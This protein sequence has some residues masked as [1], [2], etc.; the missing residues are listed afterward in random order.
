MQDSPVYVEWLETD[1]D[2]EGWAPA[3]KKRLLL[4]LYI[5][6]VVFSVI[7]WLALY[8]VGQ[9]FPALETVS[10]SIQIAAFLALEVVFCRIDLPAP[11]R[12]FLSI[13]LA[14]VRVHDDTLARIL[15]HRLP[16]IPET[17]KDNES[18]MSMILATLFVNTAGKT[19]TRWSMW[20]PP[21][22][23]FGTTLDPAQGIGVYLLLGAVEM[24][25]G[26]MIFK[27]QRGA[28]L[29]GTAYFGA[30]LVST[31][32]SWDLWDAWMREYTIQRRSFQGIP[33]R[34]GEIEQMQSLVPEA[35]LAFLTAGLLWLWLLHKRL[36][37]GR[38]ST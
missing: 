3:S 17:I 35:I 9:M 18:W 24:G 21:L 25:I 8:G 26:Y 15:N 5:D 7:W 14:K 2:P 27:L 28:L 11:G 29:L 6:W 37:R 20:A 22:P 19:L 31:W 23:V 32:L 38:F 36:S 34:D 33:L 16:Y 1:F 13:R 10:L 12:H 30:H 4:A